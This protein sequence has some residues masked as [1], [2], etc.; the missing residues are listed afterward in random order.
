MMESGPLD[1]D[2]RAGIVGVRRGLG[3]TV[4]SGLDGQHLMRARSGGAGSPERFPA[5][6]LGS[7]SPDFTVHGAPGV[8]STGLWVWCDQRVMHDL[9][10]AKAR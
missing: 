1:L 4:G 7:G 10:G 5:A 9:P 2:R 8:K 6:V 3:L